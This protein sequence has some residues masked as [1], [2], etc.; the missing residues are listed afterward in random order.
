M[1][2]KYI[3]GG[4]AKQQVETV[5]RSFLPESAIDQLRTVVLSVVDV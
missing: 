2:R 1:D 5:K 4:S 3:Q